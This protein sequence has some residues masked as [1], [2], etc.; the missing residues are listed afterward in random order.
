MLNF[1]YRLKTQV[2]SSLCLKGRCNDYNP[3]F[4]HA[5]V[6]FQIVSNLAKIL[7]CEKTSWCH[8]EHII[9]F[10][11]VIDLGESKSSRMV[12]I[13]QLSKKS[14]VLLKVYFSN[15]KQQCHIMVSSTTVHLNLHCPKSNIVKRNV[16]LYSKK[17]LSGTEEMFLYCKSPC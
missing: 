10:I 15:L 1:S 9:K 11:V 2:H 7:K 17:C 8:F 14:S 5:A 4:S 16:Y 13:K 3:F 12:S 6:F